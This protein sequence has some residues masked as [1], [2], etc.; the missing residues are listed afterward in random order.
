MG[1]DRNRARTFGGPSPIELAKSLRLRID[2]ALPMSHARAYS[3]TNRIPNALP[4]VRAPCHFI[5]RDARMG[6]ISLVPLIVTH[7]HIYIY[8]HISIYICIHMSLYSINLSLTLLM[9]IALSYRLHEKS[10]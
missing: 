3:C 9:P 5:M 4:H 7:G 6:N 8:T 1:G 10:V 2:S